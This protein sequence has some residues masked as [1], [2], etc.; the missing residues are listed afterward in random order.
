MQISRLIE[1]APPGFDFE[2]LQVF[3]FGQAGHLDTKW[4]EHADKILAC[5]FPLFSIEMDGL[6]G[7]CG[8]RHEMFGIT[9]VESMFLC[10]CVREVAP[11]NYEILA[12]MEHWKDDQKI[13]DVVISLDTDESNAEALPVI[14]EMLARMNVE[15]T[16]TTSGTGRV[17]YK[18]IEGTKRTFRPRGVI[19]VGRKNQRSTTES[20]RA[21]DWSNSWNVRAHW[22]Q[23]SSPS[24]IGMGRDGERNIQGYT[25][26]GHYQ[27]G[28]G[29]LMNKVRKVD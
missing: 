1:I 28:S 16:G 6:M 21:I 22:R 3:V 23:L 7:L 15:D 24:S 9:D 2:G 12:L 25:W 10:L 11:G 27:K 8:D 18:T 14:Q 29:P 26:I 13:R 20:G 17:R 5:P 4:T 19:Y